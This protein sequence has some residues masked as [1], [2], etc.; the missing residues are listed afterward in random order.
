MSLDSATT[1]NMK[2]ADNDGY[3]NYVDLINRSLFYIALDD[4]YLQKALSDMKDAAPTLDKYL[5]EA[6]NAE[7]RRRSFQHIA[8]SS[9][10]VEN[11]GVTI[12]KYDTS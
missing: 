9:M 7:N 10:S 3:K 1:E 6:S 12:Q 4:E 11:K 2:P 5:E 8:K